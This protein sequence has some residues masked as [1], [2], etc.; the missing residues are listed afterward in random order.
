MTEKEQ[1]SPEEE[2]QENEPE[3]SPAAAPELPA[4]PTAETPPSREDL[5]ERLAADVQTPPAAETPEDETEASAAD[6]RAQLLEE[7]D[8]LAERIKATTPDYAPPPF[9]PQRLIALFRKNMGKFSPDI[10]LGV[11]D[12]LRGSINEDWLDMD[13]WKGLWFMLNY[14][15][16]YRGDQLKRRITGDYELDEWGMDEE[17]IDTW[18]PFWEFMYSKYFRVSTTGVD[19]IPGEGRA[20]LDCNH[21]GQLPFDGATVGTAGMLEHPYQRLTRT[22]YA[23]WFPRLPFLSDMFVKMGQVVGTEENSIRLL[24]QDE[25]V[26]VFPEGYKGVG[27]LFK[28]RYRLA[29]FGRGGF[30][31]T[32]LKTQTPIIPVSIVG[33]EETYISL[34][35]SKLLA[36]MT[37]MPYFPISPRFPWLGPL[38]MIPLPTKWYIDFGEP[39]PMDQYE[40][41]AE[42]NMVLVSQLSDQ[43]RNVIQDMIY[44]RLSQRRSVFFG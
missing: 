34:R 3:N 26:S 15:L 9:S 29:R 40:A 39:V 44:T 23:T 25:L 41:G 1:H 12:K 14:T 13:T 2:A 11:L 36:K 17:F 20:L 6:L 35:K 28:D 4:V 24:E 16:E 31:K 19:N 43:V 5:R 32:A 8:R 10:Q 33:A 21:S 30:I 38:G 42:D 27:K 37:G 7:L 18:R 22:L